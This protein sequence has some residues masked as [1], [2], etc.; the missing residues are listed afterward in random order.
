MNYSAKAIAV[1][2]GLVIVAVT[3]AK[4]TKRR[5]AEAILNSQIDGII[6]NNPDLF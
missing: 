3:A 1:F 2:T 4:Y 5:R 6:D